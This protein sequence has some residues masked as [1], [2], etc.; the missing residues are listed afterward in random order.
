MIQLT[1]DDVRQILSGTP[2]GLEHITQQLNTVLAKKRG[3]T[4]DDAAREFCDQCAIAAMPLSHSFRMT[5]ER[6]DAAAFLGVGYDSYDAHIHW[7][8]F[9]AKRSYQFADAMV[10]E[11]KRRMESAQ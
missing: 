3:N 8:M 11:R 9:V 2:E 7:P 5:V 4:D 6:S 1:I 10:A